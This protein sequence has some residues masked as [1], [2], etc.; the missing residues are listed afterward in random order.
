MKIT[1]EYDLNNA[2]ER[3]QYEKSMRADSVPIMFE[4]MHSWLQ[5]KSND[6][7]D[8]DKYAIAA[9]KFSELRHKYGI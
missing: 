4:D 1:V 9:R 5:E 8:G 2:T 3:A 6:P 7:Y